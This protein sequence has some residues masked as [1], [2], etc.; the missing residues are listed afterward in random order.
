[1]SY[2]TS[3]SLASLRTT[4]WERGWNGHG[5]RQNRGLSAR[6]TGT[7]LDPDT[8]TLRL[9]GHHGRVRYRRDPARGCGRAVRFDFFRRP[10]GDGLCDRHDRGRTSTY[11]SNDQ[12]S[13]QAADGDA[14]CRIRHRKPV[15]GRR[16]QLCRSACSEIDQRPRRRH[17]L[18]DGHGR[19]RLA[20][21]SRPAGFCGGEGGARIQSGNDPGCPP[22][23]PS[24]ASNSAG[25]RHSSQ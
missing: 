18:C 17:L 22:S 5:I 13:T 24:S 7:A 12:S 3:L 19:C 15:R 1:M 14:S 11:A 23:A 4:P 25:A 10:S 16:S 9:L 2:R 8:H 20:R 21:R 6:A